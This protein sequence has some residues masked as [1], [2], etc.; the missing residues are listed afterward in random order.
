MHSA[1]G[2]FHSTCTSGSSAVMAVSRAVKTSTRTLGHQGTLSVPQPCCLPGAPWP[3]QLVAMTGPASPC[4]AFQ[5]QSQ[6][7]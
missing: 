3:P 7:L 6:S 2:L 1:L 4:H 5:V